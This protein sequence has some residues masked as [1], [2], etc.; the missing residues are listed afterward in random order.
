LKWHA[1]LTDEDEIEGRV[2]RSSY[3]GRHWDAT[4]RQ[5]KNDWPLVS[6]LV[7]RHDQRAPC[8]R[9][10]P[11]RHCVLPAESTVERPVG[12][13]TAHRRCVVDADQERS[14][15]RL[16]NARV[17]P[18]Q[19]GLCRSCEFNLMIGPASPFPLPDKLELDLARVRSYWEGL[20]RAG[21]DMPFWDDV[22]LTAIPEVSARLMLIDVFDKPVRFRLGM[23][24]AELQ[25]QHGGD[26]AGKFL[27]EIEPHSPLQ[28]LSSQS[29]ATVESRRPTYYRHTPDSRTIS[30][31]S[32]LLLPM[33]GDGRI[34]MLLGAVAWG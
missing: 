2:E 26:A 8:I 5:C 34:G 28:Y 11:E 6:I 20:V 23:I 15:W 10:I 22:N 33:W 16:R 13:L 12:E 3:L 31:Y 21:A 1:D 14:R 25:G 19:G 7:K 24:G 29:S 4:A 17:D 27:D 30:P 9:S 18:D 32:R